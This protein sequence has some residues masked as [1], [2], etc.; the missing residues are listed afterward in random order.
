M[1]TVIWNGYKDNVWVQVVQDGEKRFVM[2][3]TDKAIA[4]HPSLYAREFT[5]ASTAI[6]AGREYLYS[7]A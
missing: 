6:N 3:V 1:L 2:N 4:C 5:D 7:V